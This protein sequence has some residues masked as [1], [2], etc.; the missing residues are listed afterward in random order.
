MTMTINPRFQYK[1]SNT[2]LILIYICITFSHLSVPASDWGPADFYKEKETAPENS[3]ELEK[4]TGKERHLTPVEYDTH[5]VKIGMRNL[6]MF[7]QK[8]LSGRDNAKCPFEPSCSQFSKECTHKYG[9]FYGFIMTGDRLQRE[10]PGMPEVGDY[11]LIRKDQFL[12]PHDEPEDDFIFSA[13][14]RRWLTREPWKRELEDPGENTECSED[15]VGDLIEKEKTVP[16]KED[17]EDEI[18]EK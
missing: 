18:N 9:A 6:L 1:Y 13:E 11:P 12:K 7:W 15:P 4:M 2:L 10:Y 8:T 5:P 16:E 3:G 14:N 17:I